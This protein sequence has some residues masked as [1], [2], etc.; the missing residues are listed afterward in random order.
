MASQSKI[1]EKPVAK[2]SVSKKNELLSVISDLSSEIVGIEYKISDNRRYIERE[3]S[4]NMKKME[5]LK[6]KN[7]KSEK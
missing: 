4:K 7:R 3:K 5:D 2:D 1:H 6:Q